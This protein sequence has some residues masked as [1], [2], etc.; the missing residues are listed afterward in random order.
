V[1]TSLVSLLLVLC[2]ALP[3]SLLSGGGQPDPP[4]LSG[5]LISALQFYRTQSAVTD[6]RERAEL[7]DELPRTVAELC[8]VVQGL[9]IHVLHADRY[10][11]ALSDERKSEIRKEVRIRNVAEMLERI[12][13]LNPESLIEPRSPERRLGS[14]CRDFAVLLCSFLRHQGVPS[15]V[16]CGFATYFVADFP[17]HHWVCEYW[18]RTAM[19]WVQVDAQLDSTQAKYYGIDFNPLDVPHGKFLYAGKVY[20]MEKKGIIA[21]TET[22]D[23]PDITTRRCVFR[24]LMALN[25]MEVEIWDMTPL[26]DNALHV[27]SVRSKLIDEVASLTASPLSTLSELQRVFR[28]NKGLR[29]HLD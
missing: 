14:H 29:M 1:R 9:L 27:D 15:R 4:A 8:L 13:E 19:R 16:R 12:L 5:N 18:N 2:L 26:M 10:G 20:R 7:Y 17:Q 11:V 22:A 25:K 28:Q 21:S 3:S 23:E 24:D 6:P